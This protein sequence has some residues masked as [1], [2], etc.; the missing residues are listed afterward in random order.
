[1]EGI[2]LYDATDSS[3][4]ELLTEDIVLEEGSSTGWIFRAKYI[5]ETIANKTVI[6]YLA[7]SP[8][9]DSSLGIPKAI[10]NNNTKNK[11]LNFMAGTIKDEAYEPYGA[12]NLKLYYYKEDELKDSLYSDLWVSYNDLGEDVYLVALDKNSRSFKTIGIKDR[13]SK[14][15]VVKSVSPLDSKTRN[16][17]KQYDSSDVYQESPKTI[18]S[19]SEKFRTFYFG[20]NSLFQLSIEANFEIETCFIQQTTDS[21]RVLG[22]FDVTINRGNRDATITLGSKYAVADSD[23]KRKLTKNDCLTNGA[24]LY[25]L[26]N[27]TIEIP[28]QI[29]IFDEA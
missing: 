2:R 17:A 13:G 27:S 5:P 16:Q 14:V 4:E 8:K 9:A 20:V 12:D 11:V 6:W 21:Q 15:V 29:K 25:I 19:G 18:E 26:I 10:E 3:N 24:Y 23:D 28:I 7:E 1:M 22:K